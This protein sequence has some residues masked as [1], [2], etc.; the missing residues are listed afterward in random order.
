[1]EK[2]DVRLD[3]V[4]SESLAPLHATEHVVVDGIITEGTPLVIDGP[5]HNREKCP[6]CERPLP[7]PHKGEEEKVRKGW[8]IAV[9]VA[10]LEDGADVLDTLLD[11]CR[12]LFG[13]DSNKKVKYYTLSQALALVVQNGHKMAAD[14]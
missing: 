10:E 9:P 1:M 13:H 4:V 6:T 11:E 7:Q 2:I 5:A 3:P 8:T 14:A 12:T